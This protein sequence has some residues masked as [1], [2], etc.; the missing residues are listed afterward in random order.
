[1]RHKEFPTAPRGPSSGNPLGSQGSRGQAAQTRGHHSD[2]QPSDTRKRKETILLC[3]PVWEALTYLQTEGLKDTPQGPHLTPSL[4]RWPTPSVLIT[5]GFQLLTCG[6]FPISP[7]PHLTLRF[8]PPALQPHSLL[9]WVHMPL[10]PPGIFPSF[11]WLN[12][13]HSDLS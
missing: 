6:I 1:M 11:I 7:Q 9:Q 5:E 12:P 8:F 2:T 10:P 3:T 13:T 4:R